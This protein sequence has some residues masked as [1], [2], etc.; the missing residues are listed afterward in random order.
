MAVHRLL[1]STGPGFCDEACTFSIINRWCIAMTKK[2]IPTHPALAAI[3]AVIA[4]SN[5]PAMAQEAQ[6]VAPPVTVAPTPQAAP[7]APAPVVAA[8]PSPDAVQTAP[9]QTEPVVKFDGP[10]V[11]T[12]SGEEQTAIPS[13]AAKTARPKAASAKSS[14]KPV[15]AVTAPEAP[16][17]TATED[18]IVE[19]AAN[20][21]AVA[22]SPVALAENGQEVATSAV[23]EETAPIEP[24]DTALANT[25]WEAIGGIAGA[26]GIAGL[27]GVLYARRRRTITV[28]GDAY[29]TRVIA[30]GAP[31]P[32]AGN[33]VAEPLIVQPGDRTSSWVHTPRHA[34]VSQPSHASMRSYVDRVDD[35]PVAENP[36]LTR[37][38]RLRRAR[39][40]DAQR[41]SDGY[42]RRN[43]DVGTRDNSKEVETHREYENA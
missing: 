8:P 27:G 35:G 5:A 33:S 21:A 29:D 40:L 14:I 41:Q 4:C 22:T 17:Q 3:A 26:L 24:S 18:N 12:I 13:Q 9:V 23:N 42:D 37:K 30:E 11:P 31:L 38:N 32:L 16:V 20:S 1:V 10:V 34:M 2:L 7:S 36:F 28:R 43:A 19:D 39:F 25:D 15:S 6:T